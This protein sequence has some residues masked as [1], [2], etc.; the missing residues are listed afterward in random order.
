MDSEYTEHTFCES[1]N[2]YWGFFP[3]VEHQQQLEGI[4]PRDRQEQYKRELNN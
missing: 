3:F 4:F 2:F 1:F